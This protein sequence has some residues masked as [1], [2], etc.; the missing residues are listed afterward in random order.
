MTNENHTKIP[1][2]D[3]YALGDPLW[4]VNEVAIYLKL[5]KQSVYRMVCEARIPHIHIGRTVR[6]RKDD[7]DEWLSKSR[8]P[9]RRNC[10]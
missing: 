6:F 10:I 3:T 1:V 9:R 5:A 4:T 2:V 7:I 8:K